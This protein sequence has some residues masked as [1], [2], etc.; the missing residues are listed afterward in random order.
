MVQCIVAWDTDEFDFQTSRTIDR[1]RVDVFRAPNDAM[2]D[3]NAKSFF[4][5]PRQRYDLWYG[6]FSSSCL[7]LE[8][9][10][11]PSYHLFKSWGM[12]MCEN[13]DRIFFAER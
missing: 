3:H 9:Q 6:I 4:F 5:A 2:I 1:I 10:Q 12:Q 8:P 13:D 11:M 7:P